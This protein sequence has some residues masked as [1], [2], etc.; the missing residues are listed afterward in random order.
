MSPVVSRIMVSSVHPL[1]CTCITFLQAVLSI[2]KCQSKNFN[3]ERHQVYFI[4]HL[5]I[6]EFQS[7]KFNSERHQV[8]FIQ[9][10]SRGLCRP[11]SDVQS[12]DLI[13]PTWT[14]YRPRL[15]GSRHGHQ[16]LGKGG[17]GRFQ[18][19]RPLQVPGNLHEKVPKRF[20]RAIPWW[21]FGV[22]L[23]VGENCSEPQE[24]KNWG[25]AKEVAGDISFEESSKP[26]A[27]SDEIQHV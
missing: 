10:F 13:I 23:W 27:V 25:V 22:F 4:Q 16:N 24:G 2:V 21:L 3:S 14:Y 12:R 19:Q 17:R 26:N 1:C 20:S 7:E 15:H 6:A 8:Y 9:Q 11:D 18:I 5:S